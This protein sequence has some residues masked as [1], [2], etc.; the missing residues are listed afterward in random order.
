M[1]GGTPK[2]WAVAWNDL[3]WRHKRQHQPAAAEGAASSVAANSD[4]HVT[5]PPLR[6]EVPLAMENGVTGRNYLR[7]HKEKAVADVARQNAV[8]DMPVHI[9]A[10]TVGMLVFISVDK[11]SAEGELAVGLARALQ[12]CNEGECKFIWFVRKEWCKMPRRHEWSKSPVFRI[13]ADPSNP[14]KGYTTKEPLERVL[15]VEVVLTSQCKRDS[16]RLDVKCVRMLREFCVRRDLVC[17]HVHATEDAAC[18]EGGVPGPEEVD[19]QDGEVE[20]A[21]ERNVPEQPVGN[22]IADRIRARKRNT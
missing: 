11:A 4:A 1:K 9:D 18:A 20:H 12:D 5:E 13:A 10:V 2:S 16:P 17:A 15:P 8:R 6:Q 22:R 19:S 7:K 3:A 14:G 21:Q